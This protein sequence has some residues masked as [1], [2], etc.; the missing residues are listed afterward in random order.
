M[1]WAKPEAADDSV[2]E[3]AREGFMERPGLGT[4]VRASQDLREEF[5]EAAENG[6][7]I[8]SL[9]L[10]ALDNS[11]LVSDSGEY[12]SFD[13]P[14]RAILMRAETNMLLTNPMTNGKPHTTGLHQLVIETGKIVSE[15]RFG[16][17][18]TDV[19]M[20]D[21]TNDTKGAQMD[22]SGLTFFGLDDNRLCRW[23]MRDKSG[24]VQNLASASA[25]APVLN[26]TQGHYF[27][28]GT[29]FQCFATAGDGSI[30]VG[31]IDG[32]I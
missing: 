9:A 13:H 19:T 25:S 14:K 27:S 23:V 12:D 3:D 5:E 15:W 22:P 11:F 10:G 28:R 18:G 30:V 32:K 8:Q 16:N 31:S 20:R 29:N 4:L 1:G 17:D 24:M 21:I 2:W 7:A 6:G 26:W